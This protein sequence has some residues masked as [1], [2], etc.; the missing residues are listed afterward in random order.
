MGITCMNLF[1]I[2][3]CGYLKKIKSL[4]KKLKHIGQTPLS[5]SCSD[6]LKTNYR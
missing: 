5:T 4:I 3:V 1:Q 6:E 2:V